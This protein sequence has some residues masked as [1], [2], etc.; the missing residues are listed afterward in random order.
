MLKLALLSLPKEEKY[1]NEFWN[2]YK[3]TFVRYWIYRKPGLYTPYELDQKYE[4]ESLFEDWMCQLAQVTD[5]FNLDNGDWLFEMDLY[6]F[7]NHTRLDRQEFVKLS[8][9]RLSCFEH[10]NQEEE[11][12]DLKNYLKKFRL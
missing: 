1:M 8:E 2:K 12:Y 4:D 9:I 6:D 11:D 5:I 3:N 10:D 7:D